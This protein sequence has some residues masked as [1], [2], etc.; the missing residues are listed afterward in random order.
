ML[1]KMK[2]TCDDENP[3]KKHKTMYCCILFFGTDI[4]FWSLPQKFSWLGENGDSDEIS[5]EQKE[6]QKQISSIELDIELM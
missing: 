6:I 2:K 5:F 3:Y 4:V 1:S